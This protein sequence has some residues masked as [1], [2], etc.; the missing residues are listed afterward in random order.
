MLTTSRIMG[1]LALTNQQRIIAGVTFLLAVLAAAAPPIKVGGLSLWLYLTPGVIAAYCLPLPVIAITAVLCTCIAYMIT[2]QMAASFAIEGVVSVLLLLCLSCW[3][4]VSAKT[5]TLLVSLFFLLLVA[6]PALTLVEYYVTGLDWVFSLFV[7]IRYAINSLA[8][9]V[10]AQ[11]LMAA[12]ILLPNKA[13]ASLK[14]TLGVKASMTY[15]IELTVGSILTFNLILM[16]GIYWEASLRLTN[17]SNNDGADRHFQ[18]I[19]TSSERRAMSGIQG[20]SRILAMQPN[21]IAPNESIISDA[22]FELSDR[23]SGNDALD[24]EFASMSPDGQ[25]VFTSGFNPDGLKEAFNRIEAGPGQGLSKLD[26]RFSDDKW[27]PAYAMQSDW[28]DK[29]L[30]LAFRDLSDALEFTYKTALDNHNSIYSHPIGRLDEFNLSQDDAQTLIARP[31]YI[32]RRSPTESIRSR[33]EDGPLESNMGRYQHALLDENTFLAFAPSPEIIER[34]ST[35]LYDV[36]DYV[37]VF[38]YGAGFAKNLSTIMLLAVTGILLLGLLL[39]IFRF[40]IDGL[41]SPLKALIADFQDWGRFSETAPSLRRAL[42]VPKGRR[43]S[44]LEEI[45]DVQRE[46]RV[47]ATDIIASEARLSVIASNYDE[48][49]Q[50]LPMGVLA[51]DNVAQVHFINDALAD[52]AEHQQVAVSLIQAK[53]AQMHEANVK[54]DEWQLVIDDKT[55]KSLLL[56]VNKRVDDKNQVSGFWVIVTDLTRQKMAEAKLLQSAKLATL[57]EMSTGMAHELNQPLNVISLASANLLVSLKKGKMTEENTLSKLHRID[58]AVNRAASIIDHMRAYGRIAGE[59]FV[60]ISLGLVVKQSCSMLIEQLSLSSVTLINRMPDDEFMIQGNEIQLEQVFINLI[61]NARDAILATSDTGEIVVSSELID[62]RILVRV[63]DSGAG[64]PK[65]VLSRIFEP[66]FTTKPV[67]QG[68]GLGCSI[69]YGIIHDMHGEIW[70]E[71]MSETGG[72]QITIS[73]PL[74]T[75]V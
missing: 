38:R 11:V 5:D 19:M 42:T 3:R 9:I 7:A 45:V 52:M 58:G 66:F 57:G 59:E 28:N 34:F 17:T 12:V 29:T 41:V 6:V 39:L 75:L 43:T 46:F 22:L 24:L 30:I 65:D 23:F 15:V 72:A 47:L 74:A 35:S 50:T 36:D 71:N 37:I 16:L 54:V 61:S 63:R 33:S 20:L 27:R 48:L 64:I 31:G 55:I 67:G 8:C 26:V 53:A 68:T 2:D 70:A 73:L 44:P 49:L 69:S 1:M 14:S 25:I 4:K 60:P 10:V 62:D 32:F 13:L 51:V 56:A 21:L 18:T 40:L